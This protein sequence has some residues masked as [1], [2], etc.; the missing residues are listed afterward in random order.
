MQIKLIRL[1]R[2]N[3]GYSNVYNKKQK[4]KKKKPKQ[5]KLSYYRL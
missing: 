3:N 5:F 4:K 1:T 2:E